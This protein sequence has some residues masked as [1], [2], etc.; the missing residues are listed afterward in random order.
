MGRKFKNN[1]RPQRKTAPPPQPYLEFP[2]G[3]TE[4]AIRKEEQMRKDAYS[5]SLA[6]AAAAAAAAEEPRKRAALPSAREAFERRRRHDG[7]E[8]K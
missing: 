2:V 5:A 6:A 7:K 3:S 1:R 4:W 8:R